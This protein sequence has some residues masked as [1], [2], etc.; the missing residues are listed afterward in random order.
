MLQNWQLKRRHKRLNEFRYLPDT[1]QDQKEML[2]FLEIGSVEE[3]FSDIPTHLT[4]NEN[5]AIHPLFM[6]RN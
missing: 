2:D 5:L 3:L 4:L 1:A 6:N